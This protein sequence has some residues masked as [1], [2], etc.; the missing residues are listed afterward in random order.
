MT[1]PLDKYVKKL[2]EIQTQWEKTFAV[3]AYLALK[4]TDGEAVYKAIRD[5]NPNTLFLRLRPTLKKSNLQMDEKDANK[6]IQGV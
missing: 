6:L 3:M 1:T 4:L 2:E 5:D